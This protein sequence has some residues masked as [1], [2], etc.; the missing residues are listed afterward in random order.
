MNQLSKTLAGRILGRGAPASYGPLESGSARLAGSKTPWEQRLRCGRSKLDSNLKTSPPPDAPARSEGIDVLLVLMPFAPLFKPSIGLSLLKASLAGSGLKAKIAYCNLSFGKKTDPDAYMKIVEGEALRRALVGE[1]IFAQQLHQRDEPS[2]AYLE[3]LTSSANRVHSSISLQRERVSREL[4]GKIVQMRAAAGEFMQA[5]LCDIER[6]RPK[7]V[8]FSSTFHQHVSSLALAKQIKARRPGT[9]VVFGGSNCEGVMGAE[10]LR[11]FPFVDAVVSGE[12]DLIFRELAERILSG[13]AISNMPGVYVAPGM[14]AR[15]ARNSF[16]NAPAVK[17]LDDLPYPD[18]QDYFDQ[19]EEAG[20]GDRSGRQPDLLF[21]T[22][23]GCWWGEKSHCTF[24]GL[25]GLGMAFRSKSANRA[26]DEL[27]RLTDRHPRLTVEVVDNILDLA[28]FKDFIPALGEMRQGLQIFYE[29]KANLKKEQLRIMQ[30]AGI[31]SIQPGIESLS[32][33]VL[34]L[35]KKG[36]S[37]V[38]NIQL[39]KWCKELG[40]HPYWNVIWGFPGES[41][42]SY[43]EM[44]QLVPKLTHL[45]P[46]LSG[47]PIQLDRFSPNF[48]Q[49]ADLGFVGLRPNP[50]FSSVYRLEGEAA[51]NLA[52]HF[53]F[54]YAEPQDVERY[55]RPLLEQIQAWQEAHAAADLFFTDQGSSLHIWDFRPAATRRHIIVEGLQRRAYLECDQARSLRQIQNSIQDESGKPLTTEAIESLLQPLL[56]RALMIRL[57]N[58]Y[59][60]LSIPIGRYQPKPEIMKEFWNLAI[61]PALSVVPEQSQA[62]AGATS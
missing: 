38:Q 55:T 62:P 50:A 47:G 33:D 61:G 30:K 53:E 29:T 49:A 1:W 26:L 28:Y 56:E 51:Y 18:Y 20:I 23:R 31:C 54:D 39:L 16:E 24:C 46:P 42:R 40:I 14:P 7:I 15:F 36:V 25:N 6:L 5:C 19:F 17:D 4:L 27:S 37:A 3:D 34:R 43:C 35:M 58:R 9:F 41:P 12:A 45:T 44:A 8:G 13:R 57:D 22:S 10:T 2:Q 11:Q 48:D 60:S 52:Y 59:L 32:S 21:E